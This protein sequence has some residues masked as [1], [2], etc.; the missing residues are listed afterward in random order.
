MY[1]FI[2]LGIGAVFFFQVLQS[3][4][5]THSRSKAHTFPYPWILDISSISPKLCLGVVT[6]TDRKRIIDGDSEC[7]GQECS[8]VQ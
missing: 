8:C 5:R 1:V 3:Y 7:S 6:T 4:R 2:P